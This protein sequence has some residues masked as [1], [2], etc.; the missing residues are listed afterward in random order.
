MPLDLKTFTDFVRLAVGKFSRE[1]PEVD[2]TVKASLARGVNVA[3]AAAAAGLQ[4]GIADAVDQAFPQTADG[5]F[6]DLHGEVNNVVQ[7]PPQP[8]E[9]FCVAPG[10]LGTIVPVSTL[11][12]ANGNTYTTLIESSVQ[13]YSG[14]ILLSFAGGVATAV[15]ASAHSL[16]TGLDVDITG[17]VQTAYNG[18]YQ[19]TVLDATTFSYEIPGAA[20]L[21][22]DSGTYMAEYALLSIESVGTGYGQNIGDGGQ[23]Q[24]ALAGL[25]GT[26]YVGV[27]GIAG[28]LD[29]ESRENYRTRVL[30]AETTTPGIAAPP[31]IV[32]SA[33]SIA[34]NTRVF[35]VRPQLGAGGGTPGQAGYKPQLGETVIY[36]LRDNDVSIIPS[37]AVLAE[38]K[39]RIIDDG[40]WATNF[41]DDQLYVLAPILA[42]VDFV[43][44]SITPNTVTMQNAIRAQ[45]TAFFQDNADIERGIKEDAYLA[46]LRTVQDPATGQ[47]LSGFTLTVPSGD[48]TPDSGEINTRGTVTFP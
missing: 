38:T 24:V 26:A 30:E 32:Q 36:I 31:A 10:I 3:A 13:E 48:I 34:G 20:G 4:S 29:Q 17:A 9:G 45:L 6:L 25:D 37:L 47:F 22:P 18:T 5:E 42:P 1:L 43:F 21:T 41:V 7:F 44:A 46:F 28:G 8:A 11:L 39:E 35:L 23:L 2:P 15:T 33:K 19:V 27:E 14:S 12:T 40:N 16:A